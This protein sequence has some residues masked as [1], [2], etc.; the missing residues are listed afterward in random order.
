MSS[1]TLNLDAN[2]YAYYRAHGFNEHP[3]LAELRKETLVLQDAAMQISPEQGRLMQLLVKISGAKNI[4]EIGTFTGYSSLSMALAL[5]EGKVTCLDVSEEW[6]ALAKK[7]WKK[8]EVDHKIELR[9]APALDSLVDLQRSGEEFDLFFIDADK[10][11]YRNYFEAALGL[12]HRGS[13]ILVD[14]V[15][16][17]GRVA[18]KEIETPSTLAIRE[19]NSLLLHDA[20]IEMIMLPIGDGLTV[21]RVK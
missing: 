19:L 1:K 18:N 17:G 2:L 21:A 4:L 12:S 7:Y 20:R 16:W 8:A 11:N 6:T 15:L 9:L 3:I 10:E 5:G 14:N 13:I